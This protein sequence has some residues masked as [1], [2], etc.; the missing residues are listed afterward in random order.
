ME[1]PASDP[2]LSLD[3]LIEL[4]QARLTDVHVRIARVVLQQIDVAAQLRWLDTQLA[5]F[6]RTLTRGTERP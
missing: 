2:L 4:Q 3:A 5:Q 6:Q 1:T